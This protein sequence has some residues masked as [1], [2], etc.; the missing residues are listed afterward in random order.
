MSILARVQA[1]HK[2]N[3]LLLQF[4]KLMTKQF[5]EGFSFI[6]NGGLLHLYYILFIAYNNTHHLSKVP[7]AGLSTLHILAP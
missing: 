4:L 6:L 2:C 1:T 3:K 5:N 7:N